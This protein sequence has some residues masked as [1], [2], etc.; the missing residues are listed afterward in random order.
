MDEI[1]LKEKI[2]TIFNSL[3]TEQPKGFFGRPKK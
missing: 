3:D 2:D 1:P